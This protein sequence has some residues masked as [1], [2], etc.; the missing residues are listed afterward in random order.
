[1][2]YC[3]HFTCY[4]VV[5]LSK[6]WAWKWHS[7]PVDTEE[8]FMGNVWIYE[9]IITFNMIFGKNLRTIEQFEWTKHI[10]VPIFL[11][12]SV[13]MEPK[14]IGLSNVLSYLSYLFYWTGQ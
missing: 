4:N 14:A 9:E 11:I 3:E 6:I 7:S 2:G 5:S 12:M 13:I 10:S 8:L 1:M